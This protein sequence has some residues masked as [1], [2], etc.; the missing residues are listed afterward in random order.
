MKRYKWLEGVKKRIPLGIKLK[1][2]DFSLKNKRIQEI[3]L[4][5]YSNKPK[6][7][8][9]LGTDY[10]NLG[11]HALTL[12]HKQFLEYN[13]PGYE[14][15]EFSVDRTLDAVEFLKKS[16]TSR[17]L[18]TIKG[19]GN[20]GIE[21]FREELLRRKII[22]TF[23]SNT[24]VLFPQTVYFPDT[25]IGI[26]EFVNTIETFKQ[27]DNIYVF[28]RDLKSYSLLK[29]EKM[30]NIFLVPDIVFSMNENTQ[31]SIKTNQKKVLLCL[32]ND[33]EKSKDRLESSW[34]R[35]TL[36]DR[37]YSVEITDTV[38]D[39]DVNKQNR[40]KVLSEK[41]TDFSNSSIVI[42][43]RLH[44]MIFSYICKTP[45]LVLETYNHKVTGQYEWIQ[46][47]NAVNLIQSKS[48]LI[49]GLED[50]EKIYDE[51]IF[52]Y[53]DVKDKHILL[54]DILKSN[55]YINFE[56]REDLQ[57]RKFGEKYD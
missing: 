3:N 6:I 27:R 23:D 49:K 39:F 25:K 14:V 16:I 17:D 10:P 53:I 2:I 18:I 36:E 24:I 55:M 48:D 32:R 19:G 38:V 26:R 5:N 22:N 33:R 20:I 41:L 1:L 43:D 51:Q 54:K 40:E 7:Y 57:K 37:G 35:K 50:F 8:I 9:F 4:S 47:S 52:E 34:I 28:V 42:T 15:I 44:G 29:K 56:N 13:F 30:K 46:E 12:A 45:C 21:Y 31:G 11:D